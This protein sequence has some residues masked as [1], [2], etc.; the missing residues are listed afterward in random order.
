MIKTE[1]LFQ[2]LRR[3][4]ELI[5]R[6]ENQDGTCGFDTK[7][8]AVALELAIHLIENSSIK[9]SEIDAPDGL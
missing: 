7:Q 8:V 6:Y 3:I 2:Q 1:D 9:Q 5:R 4:E